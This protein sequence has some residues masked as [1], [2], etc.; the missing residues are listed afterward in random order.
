MVLRTG[1]TGLRRGE[2]SRLQLLSPP[3]S[4]RYRLIDAALQPHPQ[5]DGLYESLDA[6]LEEARSW[7]C[8]V[9]SQL[10]GLPI[11]V[12]VSTTAG[13]WRTVRYPQA[14]C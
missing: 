1:L 12:E 5:L 7:C 3:A 4:R 11:G 2:M 8:S 13:N 14:L 6:A 9:G 10:P